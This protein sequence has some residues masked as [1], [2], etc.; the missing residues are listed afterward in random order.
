MNV[1][2]ALNEQ[3][4]LGVLLWVAIKQHTAFNKMYMRQDKY[5]RKFCF[6]FLMILILWKLHKS[7]TCLNYHRDKDILYKYFLFIHVLNEY[8]ILC[9]E[10]FKDVN[11]CYP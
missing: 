5:T 7:K 9:H 8:E 1:K 3:K 11:L 10:K 2:L 4:L 6:N